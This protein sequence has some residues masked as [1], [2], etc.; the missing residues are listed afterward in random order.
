MQ[1]GWHHLPGGEDAGEPLGSATFLDLAP[2]RGMLSPERLVRIYQKGRPEPATIARQATT[3]H[4]RGCR[5]QIGNEP[6]LEMEGFGG[7]PA[8]YAAWFLEVANLCP[9]GTRLYYAGM[10]PGVAGW[11]DWYTHPLGR[12][13]VARASGLVCHAYGTNSQMFEVTAF[14]VGMFPD[15]PLW[16]GE[17]NPGAG[18]T[19]VLN[20]WADDHFRPFLDWCAGVPRVEAVTYFA[21][22]WDQSPSLPSSIDGAGT[23][24]ERVLRA[25]TAPGPTPQ[26]GRSPMDPAR[27]PWRGKLLTVW[28]LPD[29]PDDLIAAGRALRLDGFEIKTAD[30]DS[31]WVGRRHVTK[32]YVDALRAG[33]FRVSGW[34][35]N[36]CD[37][38][39]DAGD[40]GNGLWRGEYDA[41]ARGVRELDLDGHTFDLEIETE[42][43]EADVQSMLD[44]ARL[45]LGVPIAAHV[46]ADLDGHDGYAAEAIVAAV[47]VLRPMIY[48]PV[49]SA[50]PF[51]ASW[52]P[53]MANT[54]LRPVPFS[55]IPVCPVWGI[56]QGTAPELAADMAVADQHEVLGEAY[57]EWSVVPHLAP[58]VR[59]LIVGRSFAAPP[60]PPVESGTWPNGRRK[61]SSAEYDEMVWSPLMKAY[62][63][64]ANGGDGAGDDD[65]AA[66]ILALKAQNERRH[67]IRR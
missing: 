36:Y 62:D 1:V 6:N 46:W 26:P 22:R 50:P 61:A 29:D 30:G 66:A 54:I 52:G 48:R 14:L 64:L 67:G 53:L 24:V 40:R 63:A 38:K 58:A 42:G 45:D 34:S 28:N 59:D 35:Y 47:D 49:W 55:P 23:D 27:N 33:G 4:Q 56:T 12:N 37:G 18:H 10:S 65:D 43:N 20:D 11:R 31:S 32:E 7:G 9:A 41:A 3:W 39:V 16:L 2:T 13:A 44:V 57:W 15:K 5:V 17:V 60:A 25:W 19:F 8:E 21:Y 51:W